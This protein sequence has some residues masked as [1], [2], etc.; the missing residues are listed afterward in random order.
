M[1]SGA[2]ALVEL[3]TA[4]E[5]GAAYQ[6]AIIDEAMPGM[7]GSSIA[8]AIKQD[9]LTSTTK[10]IVMGHGD[11]SAPAPEIDGWLA[12]PVRP[13][14]LFNCV[15]E[16][17]TFTGPSAALL[18]SMAPGSNGGVYQE[19]RR[20]LRMLVVEDNAV[21]QAVVARQLKA[22]G[23]PATI[24]DDAE[25]GLEALARESFD[26]VLLDCELPG[27]DGYEAAREIRRRE[28]DRCHTVVIALTAHATAGQRE[29]C[30][31]AG[32]DDFLSKPVRLSALALALDHWT[33]GKDDG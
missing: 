27:M 32:M 21:N 11:G 8:R 31:Q 16:L 24:V 17:F 15:H 2:A 7:N 10:V 12:K 30:L 3:R 20:V 29:R 14:H 19:R 13:S 25:R 22:L 4:N 5:R 9:P 6:L 33:G 28:G 26:V 1:T 18:R 23:F